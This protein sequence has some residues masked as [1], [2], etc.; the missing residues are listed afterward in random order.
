M[1]FQ[2]N[3]VRGN[4]PALRAGTIFFDGPGGTQVPQGVID[5]GTTCLTNANANLGGAFETSKQTVELLSGARQA[6]ADFLNARSPDEIV[7]GP[8][9]TTLTFNLS[10]CLG[11]TLHPGDEIIVTR[12][13]HDANIAPWLALGERGVSIKWVDID[14]HDCTLNMVD[15]QRQFT[16]RT[17][18]VAV[19]YASNAVGTIPDVKKITDLVHE[20]NGIVFI[21]AVHYAPHGP[22]DVQALNCDFLVCSAYKFFGPHVG[23]MYGKYELL[24]RLPAYKVRP[25]EDRPP[26]KFE[27]GTQNHEGIAGTTAALDYLASIGET[28]GPGFSGKFSSFSGRRL[29]LKTAMAVIQA[30]ERELFTRLME[31]LKEVPG[32]NVYGI[33][34]PRRFGERTPTVAFTMEG[35]TP[36]EISER[37]A[38][39]HICVW[40]GNYYALAI[41]ERLGLQEN[42]GAVRVGLCHYNTA[43]EVDRLLE[44]LKAIKR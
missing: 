36:R 32:L 20:R 22:I 38:R 2:P 25:A 17:E 1:T 6:M 11:R 21:D 13:D 18:L 31:G 9:M 26:Y 29:H 19:G 30:Y 27:T 28:H 16:M 5:A 12:L 44:V 14:P 37:L 7:F 10:R 15:L 8:N 23:I 42:G 3:A 24:E 4:F 43:E 33:T 39:E 41:M 35:F 40:D 34:D